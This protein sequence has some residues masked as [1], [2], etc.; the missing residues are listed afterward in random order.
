VQHLFHAECLHGW[1]NSCRQRGEPPTC[2]ICRGK[3]SVHTARLEEFLNSEAGA[4]LDPESRSSLDQLLGGVRS[5]FAGLT[6]RDGWSEWLKVENVVSTAGIV[7]AAGWGFY[8]GYADSGDRR[9]QTSLVE[10]IFWNNSS[11]SMQVANVF[12]FVMG[13]GARL[14]FK[15]GKSE[16]DDDTREGDR[17]GRRGRRGNRS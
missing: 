7:A 4:A 14:L 13:L 8:N 5:R 10:H 11:T 2:P 12:G 15:S 17:R 6:D 9:R 1:A 16:G 3:V